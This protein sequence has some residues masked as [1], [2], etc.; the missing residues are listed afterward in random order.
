MDEKNFLVSL[1]LDNSIEFVKVN[2]NLLEKAKALEVDIGS[3]L[4]EKLNE[5]TKKFKT[6]H[7]RDLNPRPLPYQGNA[8]PA[9]LPWLDN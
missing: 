8:L 2:K 5:F 3:V 9:E 7:G 6:S 1:E 4:E